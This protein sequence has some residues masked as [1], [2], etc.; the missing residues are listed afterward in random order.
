MMRFNLKSGLWFPLAGV[1]LLFALFVFHPATSGQ[2]RRGLL[3]TPMNQAPQDGLQFRL[4]EGAETSDRPQQ[5][6]TPTAQPLSANETNALVGRLAPIKVEKDDEKEFALRERSLPPPRTGQTINETFPPTGTG[7]QAEKP[8]TTPLEITRFAPEGEVPLAPHLSITFSQPMVAVTSNDDLAAG[9]VP[10]RLSPQPEGRWRWLG[11]KTLLFAPKDRFPMATVYA[12]EIPAGTKSAWGNAL[13]AIKRWTFSTPP[14]QV[15]DSYPNGGPTTRNPLFFAGFDQRINPA[16][17]LQTIKLTAAGRTTALRLATAEEI[18]KDEAVRQRVKAAQPERWLTFR[19][20]ANSEQALLADTAYTV[21]VG[22][23]TPSAEG[24]RA[25]EKPHTFTFRTFGPLALVRHQCGYQERC[26]P[27]MPWSLEFS[28]PLDVETFDK[29][30]FRVEPE[31]PGLQISNYG[32]I[33]NLQGATKGRT[34]YRVT[35][36]AGVRDQFGQTLGKPVVVTFTTTDAQPNFFASGEGMVV[37]DPYAAPK[38][39]IYSVNH[40]QLKVTLFAVTPS[41]WGTYTNVMRREQGE[42]VTAPTTIGRVVSAKVVDL[43]AKPD[44]LTETQLDLSPALTSGVGHVVIRVDAVQPAR[45]RWERRRLNVWTTATQIG[46]DAFIDQSEVLGWASSLKD[47]KPFSEVE[48]TLVEN[49]ATAKTG[50]DG[51]ARLPLSN[52]KPAPMLIARRGNDSAFLPENF[53][54]Y[55]E[56]G[57]R[58]QPLRDALAWHVFDDRGLYKPGEEVR[59][60][61]WLRRIG[62]GPLGDVG[63]AGI[64]SVNF[65]LNDSRGNEIS[66]GTLNVNPL[67]GFD[68]KLKLPPTMNLGSA[69]LRLMAGN[70]GLPGN[71]SYHA[72]QVQEFRRPEYEVT[73]RADAGPHFIKGKAELTVA[74]SYY[75]GGGLPNAEVNWNVNAT[76]TNYTPPNRGDFS[77]GTW[78]PWWEYRSESGRTNSQQFQGRTDAAGKHHLRIDFDSAAPPRPMSV[79]ASASVQDVNRQALSGST[80]LL[81]HPAELYVGLRS[82]RTFV[83]PGEPLVVEA[84]VTDLDGKAVSQREIRMRAVQLAWTFEKGAWK[85]TEQDAQECVVRSSNEPVQCR[86]APKEGGTYRVTATTLDDRERPNQSELTLWVAGGKRPPSRE[87]AQEK[88]ELIPN[89]KEYKPGDVAEVLVQAPFANA[90][91]VLTLRRSGLVSSERFTLSGTSHTL[92]IPIKDEYTPN[93]HVQVDLVGAA[94]RT[95]DAGQPKAG[96]PK[97]P[98]FASGQLNLAVPPVTRKLTVT[99]LPRDKA[100]E[101]GGTT[102]VNVEVRDAA[103]QPVRGGEVALVVVDEAVLALTGYKLGDPLATFYQQRGDEVSEHRLRE[104]VMLADPTALIGKVKAPFERLES[105]GGMGRSASAVKLS[106]GVVAEDRLAR[107][108]AAPMAEAAEFGKNNAQSQPIQVRTN[109][110]ALAFFAAELPTDANGR[111][112][113]TVKLPDN[114]TRYRVMAVAVAGEKQFGSGEAAI[115]ARLP[116]M[117]RPSAPRFLNFGDRF[118]L[119]VVVQNQTDAPLTVDVAVRAS[120]ALLTGVS[121]ASVREGNTG[122]AGNLPESALANPRATDTAGRRVI[123]PANDRVEVRFP[124]AALKPGTARFQIGVSSG[125]WADAAEVSLPVWTPA[126]TEAFATYG[127]LD[128]GVMA[129]PVKAPSD[130]IKQFGGLEVTTSSTQLQ[131]LTDAVLYLTTYPYECAEQISSR[132][133][134]LAALRDV[135]AAFD[136]KGL[137]PADQLVAQVNRDVERLRGMQNPD[138]GFGFWTRGNESWPYLSIH[139]AHALARAKEKGFDVPDA[140]LEQSKGYLRAVEQRI[141]SWYGAEARRSLIAYALFTRARLGD[142]DAAKARTLIAQASG[143]DKMPL[144]SLGWLLP[145]L[146]GEANSKVEVAAIRRHLANRVEETAGTAHFTTA[147]KDGSGGDGGYLLLHSD[148]RADGIILSA[149]IGDDPTND[150]IPKLARGLLAHRKAGRWENTQE[151]GW[152]LLALDRYFNTYEKV[153]PDF[154]ARVWLGAGFAG[155]QAFKGRTTDSRQLNIPMSYLMARSGAQNL[156]LSK[157][158][159][160]RLY[161]RIGMQYAPSN[162]QLKAADYGFTVTRTYEAMDDPND[163]RRQEDG[164]W[165]IKAGA[166]VRVR[167]TMVAPTRRYHVALVDPLPAGLE[168]LNPALATTGAIPRDPNESAS[169]RYWWWQRT[170]YEHQNMRDE[171]VEAFAS[172]LWEGVHSYSYVARATT[173]GVFIV[174]PTK[175]EEMYHPETFGR[176]ASERVVIE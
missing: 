41:D 135:L 168:A 173:P 67:G 81:V 2:I 167:L 62:G 32:N 75:A 120:N 72:I 153:T 96:V 44:E 93:I 133:L 170:W 49:G 77:F 171:R 130:A 25:T 126:T 31:V 87:L 125:R 134:A 61:G 161:Y 115:T 16:A 89:Q 91:A 76:P 109:F 23:G 146:S 65:T 70:N 107:M 48:L 53:Y 152:V 18:E 40:Q 21:Q 88:V 1:L 175:A 30:W 51:L 11:T 52:S 172:L 79:T 19:A 98:A 144:E 64:T 36:D 114:L 148:R 140:M 150:L 149:L 4:S 14:P 160:G 95:D 24:P 73:V 113:V 9:Q 157:E 154:V 38:F 166:Q 159:P 136:A 165:R 83:Q 117:A 39:S 132:V 56:G 121:S 5:L 155:E 94:E 164:T 54:A 162:L 8:T 97:R 3:S 69:Q 86:F 110:D 119:P 141:P 68:T 45:N 7:A 151:N 43:N 55:R 129:Q 145:V 92:R 46:L 82:R 104:K 123:V 15:T 47:G 102:A 99:A 42:Q 103:G 27:F 108:A 28:N 105:L 58:K 10:A 139:V 111:A 116:L 156:T 158:G 137:P 80:T 33:V 6:P 101:P 34:T 124:A 74:A 122:V 35:I 20:A 29:K 100:L 78:V 12:V 85:Q 138:G 90:E 131:A 142:R 106:S 118:E 59:V 26:E 71:E 169:N 66:K 17:A 127:E 37:L 22:P 112:T 163:V 174:P 57:W 84:I 147:Y 13:A 143:A 176:G 128:N 50:A 60:K 63:A